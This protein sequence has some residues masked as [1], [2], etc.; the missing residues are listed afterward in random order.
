MNTRRAAVAADPARLEHGVLARE[1]GAVARA[2]SLVERG[3][4]EADLLLRALRRRVG[5]AHRVGVT[6]PPGAGKSTLLGALAGRIVAAGRS[7]GVLAVDPSSEFTHGAVLGDRVRMAELDRSDDI[8]IRSMASRGEGG[9]LGPRTDAAADVLDAAGYDWLFIESV[10]VGQVELDI[11]TVVDTTMV[12]LVP[13][14]GD[15]VQAIKAGLMEIA[16]AYVV[17]K[18]DRPASGAMVA[19]VQSCVVQQHHPDPDWMPGVLGAAATTG[20]G[21]DAVLA[22]LDRHRAHLAADDRLQR[23]RRQGLASRL[24]HRVQQEL[25]A[26]LFAALPPSCLDT[27]VDSVLSGADSLGD[28][29]GRIVTQWIET[30]TGEGRK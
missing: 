18:C 26:R 5:R 4:P 8:F 19:A 30:G 2:I 29:A 25:A 17:N 9:G 28:A 15:Q 22:E 20:A 13:E 3:A 7:V 12:V 6:G 23:R 1:R 24:R 21:L 14:S 27:A 10:G 11:R 16:D